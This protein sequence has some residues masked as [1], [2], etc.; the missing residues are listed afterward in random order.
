MT[1]GRGQRQHLFHIKKKTIVK[2]KKKKKKKLCDLDNK[3]ELIITQLE[4][5]LIKQRSCYDL[6]FNLFF[7]NLQLQ[8]QISRVRRINIFRV[9]PKEW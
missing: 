1:F 2:K 3:K 4:A 5:P 7:S 9:V 8:G 6:S